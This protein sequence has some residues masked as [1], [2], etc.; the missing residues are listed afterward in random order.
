MGEGFDQIGKKNMMRI[1]QQNLLK[2]KEDRE[3]KEARKLPFGEQQVHQPEAKMDEFTYLL[4][5][6]VY[7]RDLRIFDTKDGYV[8]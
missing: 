4:T 1:N 3:V 2:A 6:I 5:N 7:A 8:Y